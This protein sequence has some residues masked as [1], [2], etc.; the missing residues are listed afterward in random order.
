MR[1]NIREG[2][3]RFHPFAPLMARQDI[4]GEEDGQHKVILDL[5]LHYKDEPEKWVAE[6]G[7]FSTPY[8]YSTFYMY[9][10]Y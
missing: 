1:Y 3:L 7:D 9:L 8:G 4:K 10:D 5:T 6:N 2:N